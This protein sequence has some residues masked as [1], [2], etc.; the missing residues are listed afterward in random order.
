[1]KI[2]YNAHTSLDAYVI[3][4]LLE[5][6]GIAAF[7]QG[8]YLQGGVGELAAV[9]L[10]K[11][12]VHDEDVAAARLLIEAWESSQP[13]DEEATSGER[14]DGSSLM[15]FLMGFIAGALATWLYLQMAA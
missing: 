11:V 12:S 13:V 1:M 6:E 7:V 9:D 3:K 15:V 10:V 5:S 14:D 8:D 4:N 2:V